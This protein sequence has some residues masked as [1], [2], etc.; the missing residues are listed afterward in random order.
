M[1]VI[2]YCVVRID[3]LLPQDVRVKN[4]RDVLE[5]LILLYSLTCLEKHLA[6]FYQGKISIN[7]L[8]KILFK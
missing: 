2:R 4:L 1:I 3:N 8:N 7:Q 6:S 5:K